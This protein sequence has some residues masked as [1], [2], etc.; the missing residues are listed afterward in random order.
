[1][2][3]FVEPGLLTVEDIAEY[4]KK[5]VKDYLDSVEKI[6]VANPNMIAINQ[7]MLKEYEEELE[8][9]NE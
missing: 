9:L 4:R 8:K 1:M 7:E 3:D 6:C 5:R 2:V